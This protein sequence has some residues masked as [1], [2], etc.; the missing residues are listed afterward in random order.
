MDHRTVRNRP[1][2]VQP[3]QHCGEALLQH[4]LVAVVQVK[5]PRHHRDHIAPTRRS[6]PVA[7]PFDRLDPRRI[8]REM[9]HRAIGACV[10]HHVSQV[11]LQEALAVRQPARR[12]RE[13]LSVP[14][15]AQPFVALRAVGGHFDEVRPLRPDR[16]HH[17][18]VHFR[19]AAGEPPG[20]DRHRGNRHEVDLR[21]LRRAGHSH[22]GIAKTEEGEHRRVSLWRAA[23]QRVVDLCPGR[24]VVAVVE[25]L[26]RAKHFGKLEPQRRPRLALHGEPYIAARVLAEV[27]NLAPLVG[28]LVHGGNRRQFLDP[29]RLVRDQQASVEV[30]HLDPGA[31][32]GT[33]AGV[34]VLAIVDPVRQHW[35]DAGFPTG[36]RRHHNLA[37]RDN[38]GQCGHPAAPDVDQRIN[39]PHQAAAIPAIAQPDLDPVGAR[40][41]QGR[42]I[43]GLERDPVVITGPAGGQKVVANPH[44]VDKGAIQALRRDV[45]KGLAGHFFQVEG[46]HHKAGARALTA[47]AVRRNHL[48]RPHP[49]C[50]QFSGRRLAADQPI[51]A[52]KSILPDGTG[53]ANPSPRD[54]VHRST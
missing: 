28:P 16:V 41:Q 23:L 25:H 44:P 38:L 29:A 24:A 10:V 35:Q 2:I 22:A 1:H 11:F 48:S 14:G 42:Y 9:R 52:H 20:H 4:A 30:Q 3:A 13:H 47:I 53:C 54:S 36:I 45:Q 8:G 19:H 5:L 26:V 32:D 43:I 12:A 50:T 33:D 7:A 39:L 17:Q 27:I 34:H 49:R 40:V 37:A 15:P 21:D 51:E 31:F 6:R 46:L 18:P